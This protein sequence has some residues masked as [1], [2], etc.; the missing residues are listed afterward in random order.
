MQYFKGEKN[1]AK[2]RKIIFGDMMEILE[3][4]DHQEMKK[5]LERRE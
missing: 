3:Y 2:S 4:R 1:R 5:V